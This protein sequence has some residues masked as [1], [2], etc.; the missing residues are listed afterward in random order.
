MQE[1]FARY[2]ADN[3]EALQVE[4]D[5]H[6]RALKL[7]HSVQLHLSGLPHDLIVEIITEF[8]MVHETPEGS[9]VNDEEWLIASHLR[10]FPEL[11]PMQHT[12]KY[13]TTDTVNTPI[14]RAS[15]GPWRGTLQ[16]W[17]TRSSSTTS[18]SASCARP[19]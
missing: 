16:R 9:V 17:S 12:H 14:S 7:T 1:V 6:W 8:V 3:H 19:T 15:A 10:K 4:L 5:N 13:H 18:A 11:F 2:V